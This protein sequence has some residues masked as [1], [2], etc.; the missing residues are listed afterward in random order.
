M[1]SAGVCDEVGLCPERQGTGAG[2]LVR[3]GR[4]EIRRLLSVA[5]GGLG[6]GGRRFF[7]RGAAAQDGG[8]LPVEDD[9][10]FSG[11]HLVDPCALGVIDDGAGVLV[12]RNVLCR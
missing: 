10:E 8:V 7:L 2:G 9:A 4:V 12:F 1:V 3:G 11:D 6:L 5:L